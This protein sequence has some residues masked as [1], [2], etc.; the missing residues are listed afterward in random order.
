MRRTARGPHTARDG[1]LRLQMGPSNYQRIWDTVARIPYGRV[2]TYGQIARLAGLGRRARLV[3]YALH[4]SPHTLELAWHRVINT[5]GK[6]SF[7]KNSDRHQIQQEKLESEGVVFTDGRVDLV[8]Y[9]WRPS[10]EEIPDEYFAPE[11]GREFPSTT[12]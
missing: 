2:A 1:L 7:P 8:T 3:G 10:A 5:K 12:R 9:R 6:I 11:L 4:N